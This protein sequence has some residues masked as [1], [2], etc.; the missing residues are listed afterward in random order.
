MQKLNKWML[1]PAVAT[2][3]AVTAWVS[4]PNHIHEAGNPYHTRVFMSA[5]GGLP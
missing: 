2:F 4:R 5:Y 3:V 1:V